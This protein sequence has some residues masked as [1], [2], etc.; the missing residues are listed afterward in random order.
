MR[1]LV[2]GGAGFIGSHVADSYIAQGHQVAIIDDLSS[3]RR[4]N[5]NPSAR[6][7][8]MDI[9]D[10][11]IEAVLAEERPQIVSHLAAQIDVRT[12]VSD[13][14]ADIRTNVVGLVRLA[15][16]CAR[17]GVEVIVFSSTG[18]AIYGEPEHNPASETAPAR[19]LSPYGIDKR[20]GELYL[21]YFQA[22]HGIQARILRYANVYGPRQDPHGEAG[23]VAIF[24]GAMLDG[25]RPRVFGDGSQQRD[26]VYVGDVV[27]AALLAA[28]T[29]CS[30]PINI[31]TGELTSV[32]ELYRAIAE[33]VGFD[34]PPV[35]DAARP[36]EV[37]SI[38]LDPSLARDRLRWTP[39]TGLAAGIR[40]TVDYFNDAG[41][42]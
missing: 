19:P 32:N 31:G 8:E 28:E 11:G 21:Q 30:E 35:Y 27:R 42:A 22:V 39:E 10:P 6:F 20:A 14:E 12:S 4:E 40:R 7:Y 37:Q 1:V 2:T 24:A 33:A 29:S 41:S 18:G 3:G 34:E 16:A 26:F 5:L 17:H 36:G 15:S 23:V 9:G 13:P 25:R 38:S